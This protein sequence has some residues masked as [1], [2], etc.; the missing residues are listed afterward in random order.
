MGGG[1]DQFLAQRPEEAGKVHG[2]R[3]A[4]DRFLGGVFGGD[5]H[6]QEVDQRRLDALPLG[7][8]TSPATM[9][10]PRS[11]LLTPEHRTL[12]SLEDRRERQCMLKKGAMWR[13]Y[14]TRRCFIR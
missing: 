4:G 12:D 14:S 5:H 8:S 6:P 1:K 13:L 11:L 7:K 2:A 9:T 10:Y 3:G